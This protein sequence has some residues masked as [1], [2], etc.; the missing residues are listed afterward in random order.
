M[1]PKINIEGT[2][3]HFQDVILINPES[4]TYVWVDFECKMVICLNE[5]INYLTMKL[6]FT[7]YGQI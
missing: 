3:G 6:V 7:K 5:K 1:H 2:T 4:H